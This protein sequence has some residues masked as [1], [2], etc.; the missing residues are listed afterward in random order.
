MNYYEQ[1]M[2]AKRYFFFH[3]LD[4]RLFQENSLQLCPLVSI[5]IGSWRP[6]NG[7]SFLFQTSGA[8]WAEILSTDL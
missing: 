4:F 3:V 5:E 1:N 2:N 7:T 6:W 8:S